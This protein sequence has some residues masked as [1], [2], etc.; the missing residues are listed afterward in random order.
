[1]RELATAYYV[2]TGVMELVTAVTLAM[3][4]RAIALDWSRGRQLERMG[5]K[6]V[7]VSRLDVLVRIFGIIGT[8]MQAMY[9]Y[10][11]ARRSI[12]PLLTVVLCLVA[13]STL[14]ASAVSGPP[15]SGALLAIWLASKRSAWSSNLSIRR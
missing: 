2:M 11:C 5:R 9:W 10:A 13:G 4:V 15:G 6:R 12:A 7:P 8:V 14:T 3:F 1:M